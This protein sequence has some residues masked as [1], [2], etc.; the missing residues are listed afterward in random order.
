[1]QSTEVDEKEITVPE[2]KINIKEIFFK[3]LSYWPYF[4]LSIAVCF[5]I[6]Y[7]QIRYAT[8]MYNASVRMLIADKSPLIENNNDVIS[9]AVFGSRA[10]NVDNELQ[11]MRSRKLLDRV[12]K[13][14][15][16]NIYYY[17]N[18]RFKD[19]EFYGNEPVSFVTISIAD[20]TRAYVYKIVKP[21]GAGAFFE[22]GKDK[23]I[24]F[25]WGETIYRDG[26][27]FYLR[28]NVGNIN[29]GSGDF[30]TIQ[31]LPMSQ[32]SGMVAGALNV[33][34]FS[35]STS[36]I[37]VSMVTR[38]PARAVATL[39]WFTEEFIASDLEKKKENSLQI[40]QFIDQR[41]AKVDAE[42]DSMENTLREF[43]RGSNFITV[44]AEYGYYNSKVLAKETSLDDN[45]FNLLLADYL[46]SYIKSGNYPNNKI[47][48]IPLLSDAGVIASVGR[49]NSLQLQKDQ[50]VPLNQPGSI[51]L[52][53]IDN[54]LKEALKDLY[55]T[56]ANYRKLIKFKIADDE[57]KRLANLE[58][59]KTMPLKQQQ[60]EEMLR[61]KLLK[62]QTFNFLTQRREQQ[63]ISSVSTRSNYEKMDPASSGGVPFQPKVD[64]IRL[65]SILIGFAIPILIIFLI[66]FLN[67]KITVKDDIVKRTNLPIVGEISHADAVESIVIKESR[68]VI[69]E[70]FRIL[71]TNLQYLGSDH[72]K[73]AK[74]ILVTSSISG[75]GKSFI[76]LNLASVLSVTGKKVA[77]LEFDLRKLH[78][79]KV[80]VDE[81]TGKG[82]TNYLINQI[83]DPS[84]LIHTI[85][86][87]PSL[88]LFAT[89]PLPPNPAELVI[90]ER[91]GV[92]ISW[93]K[94]NYDYVI[95]DS[96]PV[97]PV[98]DSFALAVHSDVVLYVVRQL[99]TNKKQIEFINDLAKS[100][101]KLKN[102]ALVINDVKARGRYAYYGYG[103]KYGGSYYY[104]YGGY[105][106]YGD[107]KKRG[108]LKGKK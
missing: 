26:I 72:G 38:T 61:K 11:F 43:K 91:T 84:E 79:L 75:E 100:G 21:N 108:F 2:N 39:N 103:G 66:D 76:S 37:S 35:A 59:Q 13:H 94:D 44:E 18:G 82:I 36:I 42:L 95:M 60:Y 19:M 48:P 99:Y 64:Q 68:S 14:A 12:V 31:W 63:E 46:E 56:I 6:G 58:K 74:T 87:Y 41:L 69:A 45:E 71:R 28:K 24:P 62:Q 89:G 33:V 5:F 77:L 15:N 3:Y 67:D 1:M 78:S 50:A 23:F 16:L 81:R 104:G 51:V 27:R 83:N 105:N 65:T 70:Q 22:V 54:N 32:A 102:V 29:L 88:H 40:M 25:K 4:I 47:I 53:D 101:G 55:L 17:A 30:L 90:S 7:L 10:I 106:Y 86:D 98:S 20:S 80:I 93:L 85:A 96:A 49:Y 57:K 107:V 97:G 34:P 52:R 73:R 8:P 9:K 92:F